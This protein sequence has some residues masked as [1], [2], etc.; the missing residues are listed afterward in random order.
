MKGK[1]P[2]TYH[3]GDLREALVKAGRQS[4]ERDG[5]PALTLRACARTAGVSHAAPQH[6]FPT[7]ADL[8]A[9]IAA[10]GYEDFHQALDNGA[11]KEE[12]AVA[13][14]QAMGRSYVTFAKAHPAVY[15]LMF[16]AET[17]PKS[18]RLQRAMSAAWNQLTSAVTA[19]YGSD[20]AQLRAVSTW[21][22]VHGFAMLAINHRLPPALDQAR[23]LEMLTNRL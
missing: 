2:K 10:T 6:H 17:P 21:S 7:A 12:A 20:D 5:A 18:E 8:L 13:K 1:P 14:L 22:L 19:A 23:A 4:L 16:G 9:E 3:H 15:K 11:A